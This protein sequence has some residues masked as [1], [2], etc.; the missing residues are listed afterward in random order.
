MIKKRIVLASGSA[1]RV[2]LLKSLGLQFDIIPHNIEE[3]I[4][5]G[6]LPGELVMYLAYIKAD[7]VAKKEKN[8]IIIA[9]DTVVLHGKDILGKPKDVRDA[10]RILSMLSNSDHDVVSGVCIMD[11]PSKRKVLRIS[12]TH[13]KMKFISEEEIDAYIKSGEPMDKAGA[14]AIQGEGRKFIE[15]I[16]GSLSNVVGLPLGLVLEM[17][18]DFTKN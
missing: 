16:N 14:Y 7:D 13:I 17:L 10:K 18:N 9:A 15:R 5:G 2:A 4:P 1:R 11:M 6:V 3:Y 8:A 12:R